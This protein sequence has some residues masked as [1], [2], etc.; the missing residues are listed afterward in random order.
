MGE[1][2]LLRRREL[3]RGL[4]CRA[5]QFLASLGVL[6]DELFGFVVVVTSGLV[7]TFTL[8]FRSHGLRSITTNLVRSGCF[9]SNHRAADVRQ[10]SRGSVRYGTIAFA[11]RIS[12]LAPFYCFGLPE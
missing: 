8:N 2:F 9:G 3:V 11:R 5:F 1:R 10:V 7:I 12:R 4:G 6:V